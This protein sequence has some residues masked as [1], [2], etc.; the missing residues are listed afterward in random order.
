MGAAG[1][2]GVA[3]NSA[4]WVQCVVRDP[5]LKAMG[6]PPTMAII[7]LMLHSSTD[8]NLQVMANTATFVVLLAMPFV[9]LSVDRHS[10]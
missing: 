2:S 3:F 4:L 8:F 1:V 10:G 7:A 9:A 5:F 6:F